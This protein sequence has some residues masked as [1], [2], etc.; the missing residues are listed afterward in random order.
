MRKFIKNE[1]IEV[2]LVSVS[3]FYQHQQSSKQFDNKH[4]ILKILP[5]H[6][7]RTGGLGSVENENVVQV[8]LKS[9]GV[10]RLD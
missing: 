4:P 6:Y 8:W 5:P 2:G 1:I 3:S 7:Q 9:R 10:N